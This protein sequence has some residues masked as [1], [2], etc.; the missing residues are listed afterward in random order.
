MQETYR[1]NDI[2]IRE[3]SKGTSAYTVVSGTVEV[4]IKKDN[5]KCVLAI[6]G[7]KQIFGEMG[8]I[9]DKPRSATVMALEEDTKVSVMTRDNFKS[10][11]DKNPAAILPI[12]K[13]LLERLRVAVRMTGALCASCASKNE[14][15]DETSKKVA[16]V[17]DDDRYV[18][19]TG[20]ND[21]SEEE[22]GGKPL[23]IKEF[24]FKVGR[25]SP[26]DGPQAKD[27]LANNDFSINEMT[28]PFYVSKNHFMIE[29]TDNTFF[30]VDRGSKTGVYVNGEH[31]TESYC[32]DTIDDNEI[33]V[34][35]TYSPYLFKL[36]I[37]DPKKQN[38]NSN[39]D[40]KPDGK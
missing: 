9:E 40:Q 21:A 30:V 32:I 39:N 33:I 38:K 34:G 3:G 1:E 26:S 24:P 6:L 31:V 7:R 10:I 16:R 4:S 2:I 19:I 11:Y 35:T 20:L 5:I 25:V 15:D 18:I 12:V 36:T 17:K 22:L 14:D 37:V 27:V 8:L 29:K 23:D 28:P 13:T